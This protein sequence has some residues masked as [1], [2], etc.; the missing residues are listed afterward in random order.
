MSVSLSEKLQLLDQ[1]SGAYTRAMYLTNVSKAGGWTDETSKIMSAACDLRRQ[2]DTLRPQVGTEWQDSARECISKVSVAMP[3][4]DAAVNSI[5]NKIEV[6]NAFA[7]AINVLQQLAEIAA[8]VA[9]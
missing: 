4:L 6:L 9:I 8:A 3:L 5:H 2:I 7:V 1:L